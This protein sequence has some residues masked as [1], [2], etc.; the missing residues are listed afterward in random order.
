M[1]IF[2]YLKSDPTERE[3]GSIPVAPEVKTSRTNELKVHEA[4]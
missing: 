2:K 4:S 3:R 1:P